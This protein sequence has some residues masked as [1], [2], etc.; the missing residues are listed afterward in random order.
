MLLLGFLLSGRGVYASSS[1]QDYNALPLT[2]FT[3]TVN[4]YGQNLV[5]A[6]FFDDNELLYTLDQYNDVYQLGLSVASG[7]ISVVY[8][9]TT[10]FIEK[11]TFPTGLSS[12][13]YFIFR[14][15]GN[16]QSTF[17]VS[18][19]N[20][21]VTGTI[22]RVIVEKNVDS[23]NYID[24]ANY[25][26][27]YSVSS[28]GFSTLWNN[29]VIGDAINGDIRFSQSYR[30]RVIVRYP[31]T[32]SNINTVMSTIAFSSVNLNTTFSNI[33]Y[34]SWYNATS[35]RGILNILDNKLYNI[36]IAENLVYDQL[37]WN[38]NNNFANELSSQLGT[39]S[40]AQQQAINQASA[41]AHSDSIAT[42][43][44][45]T[46]D[47]SGTSTIV[48]G[49]ENDYNVAQSEADDAVDNAVHNYDSD[50]DTVENYD[51]ASFFT[52]QR[53]AATFWRD[54]GEYI[55]NSG[56]LGFVASG[57]IITTLIT[58]FV[59]MLRL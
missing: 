54:V 30:I 52:S 38:G 53:S 20:V 25:S 18:S 59:F 46:T 44:I 37:V 12:A 49:I 32:V 11:F 27:Y 21:P 57:V 14:T 26:F 22:A 31:V 28:T 58:L 48:S 51:F 24:A 7:Y 43:N 29:E 33:D 17:S 15:S 3:H 35:L 47:S 50:L 16:T 45:L 56:E 9:G 2:G 8:E 4:A 40:A 36:W 41:T 6:Y 1:L 10:E 34:T 19:S 55:L 13:C 39:N 5:P 42:Q 23:C